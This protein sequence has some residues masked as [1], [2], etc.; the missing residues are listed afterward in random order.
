MAELAIYE[1][2]LRENFIRGSG[3]GGQKINKTSSCVQLLHIPTGIEVRCQR[4]RSQ[5]LN[6]FLARRELCDRIAEKV[7]REKSQRQQERE[8]IRRQKRRRSRRQKEKMLQQK[9]HHA[10]KKQWRRAVSQEN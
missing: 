2:D 5:A 8:K 4:E 1:E 9:H 3:H 10:E 6:R 7:F